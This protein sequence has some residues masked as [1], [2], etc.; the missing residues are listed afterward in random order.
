M[1]SFKQD[2]A[3]IKKIGLYRK[4]REISSSQGPR[5][6]INGKPVLLM[7]SNDY[8]GFSSHPAIKRLPM[9]QYRYGEQ[10]LEH[11]GSSAAI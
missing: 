11:R 2:L 9:M 3:Q 1:G 8:L 10:A 6:I 7:A 4:L 5:V